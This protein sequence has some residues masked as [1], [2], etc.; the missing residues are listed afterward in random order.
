MLVLVAGATGYVGGRLVPR[1]LAE[2]HEVRVLA[3]TP[4]K[5]SMHPWRDRIE[6]VHGD[7]LD[8][9][10]LKEAAR[11][12]DAAYYLV[13]SMAAG[14]DYEEVDREAAASFRDAAAEAGL[15]RIVYLGGLARDPDRSPHMRSRHEVGRVLADGAT[16]VTE[17]R[18]G[19]IIGSGSLSFE[20]LRYLTETLPVMVTPRWVNALC[21]PVAV[22]DVLDTLI[23]ALSDPLEDRILELGG[24]DTLTYKEMM[25]I[26]AEEAGLR[27]RVVVPVPVL[28]PRLSSLWIGLITPLPP[29]TAR[30]IVDSI[31]TGTV[32]GDENTITGRVTYR[33]AIQRALARLPGGVITRWTDAATTAA[34]ASPGDPPWS[35]G[36]LFM[37]RQVVPTHTED[38]HLYW[39]FSRVGG[40]TGYYGLDW[41]WRIRGILDQMVGGVGLRRGRRHPTEIRPGEAIDFWRVE[42][43]VPGLSMR[44]RAEMRIPGEAWLEWE[45]RRTEHG[46]DLVQ[47]SWFRPRGLLGRLYW[48]AM[49]PG[50]RII[51]PRMARRIAAAAEERS[52]TCR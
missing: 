45:T 15:S 51:F 44:L 49:L 37:D 42:E 52:F 24:P 16:P 28:S 18:S 33:A 11:G 3:R 35:G 6:V 23:A 39:A 17:I 14:P 40:T 9:V 5:L 2:G 10:S 46:S 22:A 7:V 20:M 32:V 26:Y 25:R 4:S 48:Y 12:C 38:E 34:M 13:H 41:A 43:V 47:T 36:P 50:H 30:P 21:Q 29:S 8:P 31:R 1:L 19:V 27:R